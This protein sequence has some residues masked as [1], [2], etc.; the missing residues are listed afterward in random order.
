MDSNFSSKKLS[1]LRN[2]FEIYLHENNPHWAN[3]T[4]NTH[5]SDAFFALNNNVGIDFWASFVSE[6]SMLDAREKIK[7]FLANTKKSG[8]P[9]IRAD[10][11]LRD[12]RLLKTFLDL[13]HPTL[14]TDWSKKIVRN[15]NLKADF[16]AW[17][18][19]QKKSDGEN[20][21]SNTINTYTSALKN[22]TAK[23]NLGN[24]VLADLFFYTS[25]NEFEAARNT[26][27]AAPN[28]DEVD[29]AAG[30]KAFSNAMILY[31][32]FLKELGKPSAWIFQANPKNYDAVA[33]VRD[34]DKLTW[35]VNQYSKQIKNG[36][37]VYI[38]ISGNDSGIIA[39]GTIL[40]DPEMKAP[41]L[42]DPYSH[43]EGLG[44]VPRLAVDIKID[45]KLT[46]E[47][48]S[49]AILLEDERT[50]QL[51]ILAFAN[52]TN[53]SV[54]KAEK[55]VIESI[56]DGT[57]KRIPAVNEPK[58]TVEENEIIM[59]DV[60]KN[61]ILYGPP[62]T[63]KTYNAGIYAV[64][65]IEN[66]PLYE[67]EQEKGLDVLTRFNK[68]KADGRIEFITFHQSYGYEEFIEGIK[69]VMISDNEEE[70]DIQYEITSGLFKSFCEKASRPVLKDEENIGLNNA[71]TVWKVSLEGTGD[72]PTRK[73]CMDNGHIRIGWD[74]YGE[75][76]TSDTVFSNGG[77]HILNAF[78]YKMKV[79]DIVLSCYSST[80][81]DAI[82]I[83]TGDYEWH[84]EYPHYK[85]LRNVNWLVKDISEDI[86]EINNGSSLTLSTVYKLNVSIADV[87]EIVK[88][89]SPETAEVEASD[90]NYV[91]IIDEI[92]RGNI[93]KIFGELITLIEPT[94]RLGQPEEATA[95]L[96]YSQKSFG[97][98]NNVYL[99]GTM[100]TADRSIAAIDTALRRRFRFK[101]MLPEARILENIS[102]EDVSIK[103]M[104]V[105][106]NERI[107]VLYDRE[108]TIGHAYFM[109][110]RNNP[111]IETLADI[112][113]NNII[114][115][116]QEYFYEDYEKIRLVLGDN[117][118]QNEEEQFITAKNYLSNNLFGNTDYGFDETATYE[119]N[120]ATFDNIE[121]Y[122]SI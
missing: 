119:V 29:S 98:P 3:S 44:S 4:I 77:K 31:G 40:C 102:V 65:V 95:R 22:G 113:A 6:E 2:E 10:G 48:V 73:E 17:M 45:R 78:I 105:R 69:P 120:A 92:N 80:T 107:A 118:K 72:N 8:D 121:A 14:A 9:D 52:A 46:H 43:G 114:P 34:L 19:K 116:L 36:D 96:P 104:F 63:G 91:F 7:S 101:E 25:A 26:I 122:R 75:S 13:K 49:R 87:M 11:Y 89:N 62:G 112:F 88:K 1:E 18:S 5:S 55:E 21:T 12:L 42:N 68:Y 60:G 47:K 84:N 28:F 79:G 15:P 35:S 106:M 83:V 115:L 57:Y 16:Q 117:N 24:A 64:A 103:D 56:I 66:K 90:K 38:W 41:D 71:P 97:V 94:K 50:K 39:S 51:R 54:T 99:I 109:P 33:A 85:R 108:H 61:T 37:K 67:I 81:T 86:T 74:V 110:L 100:N 27:L 82:G 20:Y 53:F 70:T 59:T 32:R 76:I 93:S 58:S 30:N 111:T 23:L